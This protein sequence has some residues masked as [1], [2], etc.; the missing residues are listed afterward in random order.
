MENNKSQALAEPNGAPA[1]TLAASGEAGTPLFLI[2]LC[3]SMTPLQPIPKALPG[4]E[5]YKLYQ[6][7]RVEDGRTRYRL[8]LG[9]FATEAEAEEVLHK[10]REQYPT[11]FTACLCE[12]DRRYTRGYVP[13]Q[14]AK[15]TLTVVARAPMATPTADRPAQIKPSVST[16]AAMT[17]ATRS[18]AA[19]K[20]SAQISSLVS[21]PNGA[22][23]APTASA[24]STPAAESPTAP[25]TTVAS[26]RTNNPGARTHTDVP[27]LTLADTPSPPAPQRRIASNE[28]FHVGKGAQIPPTQLSLAED[29][30]PAAAQRAS[31]SRPTSRQ[32]T[33]DASKPTP[34]ILP[35]TPTQQT[36]HTGP[37]QP[38]GHMELDSTQTI[39]ALT[40]EELNDEGKE[41]WFAI[42][43]AVSEYPVNLE[44]MPHLDIFEAYRLYSVATAGSGKITHS[45]RLGF[46]REEVSAEAVAGYLKAFFS[47]PTVIRVS[48]AEHERF[49]NAKLP[50]RPAP[51]AK[52][53]NVIELES[54]RN[55]RASAVPTVTTEVAPGPDTSATGTF[56]PNGTGSFR[57]A[58][59][60]KHR[61]LSS[62]SKS[63]AKQTTLATK[64]SSSLMKKNAATGKYK[65]RKSLA[66]E[67]LEE[68]KA[69]ELSESGI[70][71][72]PK[73]ESLLS[74]LVDRLR[75]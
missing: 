20:S 4:L 53:D 49:K 39:R 34:K 61:V 48:V 72:M 66:E 19:T 63:V 26:R 59:T 11:A 43:L 17:P 23:A 36:A 21:K 42:Q 30:A 75:R 41:K 38:S 52:K 27:E 58:D 60:A 18:A 31:S 47:S 51:A 7:Q 6:V 67:L 25:P 9:F 50:T 8:R 13:P 46:F 62:G 65:T 33:L 15:P 64:R 1:S 69:V 16:Q 55:V 74:R 22:G 2:N 10:V 54:A 3:A 35:S 14:S 32:P 29:T 44:T 28:P 40:A 71:K 56:R 12:E 24:A 37:A 45:L 68:A 57:T 5:G 70:Y 73:N